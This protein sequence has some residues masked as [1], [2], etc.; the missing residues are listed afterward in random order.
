M[1]ERD[2]VSDVRITVD[3]QTRT[4]ALAYQPTDDPGAPSTHN[5]RGEILSALFPCDVA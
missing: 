1:K 5:L 4:F 3:P 2:F